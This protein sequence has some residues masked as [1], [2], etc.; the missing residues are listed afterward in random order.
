MNVEHLRGINKYLHHH[1]VLLYH[2]GI[3]HIMKQHDQKCGILNMLLKY[4]KAE[5][6]GR[7][8]KHKY[9]TLKYD[10]LTNEGMEAD[11]SGRYDAEETEDGS[12][13]ETFYDENSRELQL[14]DLTIDTDAIYESHEEQ[15]HVG[16]VCVFAARFRSGVE[17]GPQHLPPLK[18][19]IACTQ[20]RVEGHPPSPFSYGLRA[21]RKFW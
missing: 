3:K 8:K 19:M 11:R 1:V 14:P 9:D 20:P 21:A 18:I 15:Q 17:V 7:N 10:S 4:L 2:F 6:E 12:T 13:A 16:D 5:K